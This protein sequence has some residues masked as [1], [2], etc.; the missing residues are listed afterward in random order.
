MLKK[1]LN[2]KGRGNEEPQQEKIR[3]ETNKKFTNYK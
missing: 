1:S 3:I 2:I